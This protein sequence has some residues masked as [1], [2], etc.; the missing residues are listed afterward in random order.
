MQR[1]ETVGIGP[2]KNV[3]HT[4]DMSLSFGYEYVILVYVQKPEANSSCI[5]QWFSIL[6]KKGFFIDLD[7]PNSL[8]NEAGTL[9]FPREWVT[10]MC[11]PVWPYTQV[12]AF[13][14]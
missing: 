7:L 1:G 5:P 12:R 14:V 9:N 6:L 8:S 4:L 10:D 11:Y 3:S 13:Q 2:R